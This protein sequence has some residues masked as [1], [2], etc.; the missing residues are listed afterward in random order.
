MKMNKVFVDSNI[1]VYAFA[2]DSDMRG[3]IAREFLE[4]AT[5]T[6]ELAISY[7]V[8]NEATHV[9]KRFGRSE[10]ELRKAIS[11][12]FGMCKFYNFSQNHAM[13]ASELRETISISYWDSHI[14]ASAIIAGCETLV[15]EDFQDRSLIRDVRIKNIFKA[16]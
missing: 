16:N 10:L 1:W 3:L 6:M 9:L 7:Q 2:D 4:N 5:I 8:I 13:L 12:M 15:S 11:L 14:V